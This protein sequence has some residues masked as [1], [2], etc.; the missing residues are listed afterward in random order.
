[1]GN[2]SSSSGGGAN[3]SRALTMACSR[4]LRAIWG[5]CSVCHSP[6]PRFCKSWRLLISLAVAGESGLGYSSI[7]LLGLL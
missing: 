1:M 6:S 2:H 3:G 5:F 4:S 7:T